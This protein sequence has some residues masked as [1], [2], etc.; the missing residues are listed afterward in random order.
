[1]RNFLR[2]EQEGKRTENPK[3][4]EIQENEEG[5]GSK[6]TR[7]GWKQVARFCHSPVIDLGITMHEKKYRVY[8]YTV[9]Q[10]GKVHSSREK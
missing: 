8:T 4:F 2:L 3:I 10:S 1:M 6:V 5:G 9:S 7:T